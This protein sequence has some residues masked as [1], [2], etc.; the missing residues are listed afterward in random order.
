MLFLISAV[1]NKI[2]SNV[3]LILAVQ[4]K[5]KIIY[6]RFVNNFKSYDH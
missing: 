2:V 6:V 1:Q 3:Y 4:I 5:N